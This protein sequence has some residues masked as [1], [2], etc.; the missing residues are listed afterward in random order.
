MKNTLNVIW[1]I[2]RSIGEARAAAHFA[3]TGDLKAAENMLK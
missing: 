3:R 1:S 2:L